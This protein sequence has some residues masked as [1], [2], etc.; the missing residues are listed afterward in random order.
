MTVTTSLYARY[1]W[2]S[3]AF[4]VKS[5]KYCEINGHMRVKLHFITRVLNVY[6][7]MSQVQGCFN[8]NDTQTQNVIIL[9]QVFYVFI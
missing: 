3:N 1:I 6:W 8:M 7:I 5:R 9:F 2:R 4:N